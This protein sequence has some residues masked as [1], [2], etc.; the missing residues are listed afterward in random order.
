M[1]GISLMIQLLT[2]LVTGV[3]IAEID[4]ITKEKGSSTKVD[5]SCHNVCSM[6]FVLEEVFQMRITYLCVTLDVFLVTPNNAFM[7]Q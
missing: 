5:L 1:S 4:L 7:D 2:I 3:F 6:L